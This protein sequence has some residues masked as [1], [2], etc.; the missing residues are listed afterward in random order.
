MAGNGFISDSTPLW[1]LQLYD[2]VVVGEESLKC[3]EERSR[4]SKEPESPAIS[5]LPKPFLLEN[6]LAMTPFHPIA[7]FPLTS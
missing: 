3:T 1:L 5:E 6:A 2:A 7:P 4:R